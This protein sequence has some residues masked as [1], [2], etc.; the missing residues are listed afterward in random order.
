MKKLVALLLSMTMIFGLAACGGADTKEPEGT[1]PEVTDPEVVDPEVTDPEGTEPEAAK[2][3]TVGLI[4]IGD[5]NDQGYTYNFMRGKEATTEKLAEKG[6]EV[7]WIEKFNINE[8]AGCEDANIELADAGCDIIINNSFGHEDFMLKVAPDYPEIQFIS[9]TGSKSVFSD[10]TNV[11][12]VFANIYEG[13]YVAGVVA[14]MKIQELIDT[15]V[16]TAEEAKIGYVGAFPFPEVISG[17]TAFYLGAKTV[18]PSVTMNVKYVN[19][20]SDATEE[21]NAAQA[22]CDEGAVLISQHSD[23]TTP[24]TAA[25]SNGA[26]HTGYNN[27]MTGVAPEASLLSCRIDW[28]VYFSYA[29]ETILNGGELEKDWTGGMGQGAVVV[30]ELNEAIAA[31]GTAEKI[32]EVEAGLADGSINVFEGPYTGSGFAFGAETADTLVMAEG[33]SFAESDVATGSTSAPSFYWI[34]EGITEK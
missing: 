21:A 19:S 12:N 3:I 18:C 31:P 9:C 27:D 29:I 24:A 1:D 17:F 8:D 28:S 30:S 33:E 26:F 7:K 4:C 11:H 34:I 22:L 13:R 14:G 2:T 16:I 25:Q 10:L 20:W 6:I 32:I 15:G 23:N 5:E